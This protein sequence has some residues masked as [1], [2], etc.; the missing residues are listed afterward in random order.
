MAE[1]SVYQK[2]KSKGEEIEEIDKDAWMVTFGDLLQLLITFFVLMISMSSMDK[3]VIQEMFS[4]FTGGLGVL[5]FSEQTVVTP[6]SF[7][8][9]LSPP[10]MDIDSF[11][12]FLRIGSK[13]LQTAEA[14][15]GDF[16]KLV[17][18]VLISGVDIE[19]HGRDFSVVLSDD[20]L[21]EKGGATLSP[22]LLPLLDRINS[23]LS[24]SNNKII[25]EGHTD[26]MPFRSRTLASNWELSVA[27]AASVYRY[28]L[29]KGDLTPER[30]DIKGRSSYHPKVGNI[31]E[32]YR[33]R[34]RRIEIVIKQFKK[35]SF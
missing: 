32:S 14:R 10:S 3:Q 16:K 9:Y 18:S 28:F 2:K 8:P 19:R 4:L 31:S 29:N 27:R 34:N 7:K 13:E 21:F 25:I 26:D 20:G 5:G 1:V 17:G 23:I 22:A 15:P 33:K 30:M 35:E 11:K 24:M 6:P 12:R